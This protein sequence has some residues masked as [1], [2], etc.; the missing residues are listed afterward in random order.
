MA[1]SSQYSVFQTVEDLHR[2]AKCVQLE[3]QK[4]R[5]ESCFMIEDVI[6]NNISSF[7]DVFCEC[8]QL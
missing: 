6:S 7:E 5:V 3:S 1:D 8:L 4:E 2:M